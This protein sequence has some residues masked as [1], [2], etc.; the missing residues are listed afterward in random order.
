MNYKRKCFMCKVLVG[1]PILCIE[2]QE[3]LMRNWIEEHTV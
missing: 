1:S 3:S 2:C